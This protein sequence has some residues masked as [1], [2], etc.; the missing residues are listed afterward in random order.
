[1]VRG[2]HAYKVVWEASVEES[3]RCKWEAGNPHDPYAVS[4][5]KGETIVG[6]VPRFMS[7]ICCMFLHRG[8]AIS[9]VVTGV[10]RY[11]ADLPQGS[12]QY[13]YYN[14]NNISWKIFSWAISNT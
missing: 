14:Y 13:Y 8:G 10:R 4:V 6:H 5:L 11:S 3:L 9:S 1:M 7:S 12:L 2:Y